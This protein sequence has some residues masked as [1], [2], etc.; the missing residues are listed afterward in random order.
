M[1]VTAVKV[2]YNIDWIIPSLKNPSRLWNI[3]S[4]ITIA[5]VGLFSKFIIR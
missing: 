5:C 1:S 4:S 3:A 2:N